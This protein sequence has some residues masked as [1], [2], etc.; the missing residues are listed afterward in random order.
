[1]LSLMNQEASIEEIN[2][3]TVGERD[4]QLLL[5]RKQLFGSQ[6]TGIASCPSCDEQLEFRLDCNKVQS[7]QKES[8][9]GTSMMR[10]SGLD[11]EFKLPTVADIATLDPQ[12]SQRDNTAILLKRCIVAVKE[13]GVDLS[14]DAVPEEVLDR[15]TRRMGEIEP[16]ADMRLGLS[17]P[18]CTHSWLVSI[19]IVSFLWQ[20]I[21]AWASRILLEVHTIA[22]AYGW[23]ESEILA[24]TTRRRDVYLGM[25][26]S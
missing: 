20:E 23:S 3:Y 25:I 15:V 16:E 8:R 17:C 7:S 6:L 14:V 12:L 22:A 13:D 1:M 19:D 24:M 21:H 2:T 9:E 4:T 11:V 10:L 18:R 26:Q 5:L